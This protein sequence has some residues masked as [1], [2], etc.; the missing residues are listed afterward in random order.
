MILQIDAQF[1]HVLTWTTAGEGIAVG[2]GAD[3]AGLVF[4]RADDVVKREA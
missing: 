4:R 1:D 3:C 2:G